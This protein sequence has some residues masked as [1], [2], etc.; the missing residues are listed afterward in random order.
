M[1]YRIL[2]PE[3]LN[4][5]ELIS[6]GDN[7]WPKWLVASLVIPT[8][9]V[10]SIKILEELRGAMALRLPGEV[11]REYYSGNGHKNRIH[12][13]LQPILVNDRYFSIDPE[14]LQEV[15]DE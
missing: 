12:T 10:W 15:L 1:L 14:H 4:E 6:A 2:K 5:I 11:Y 13:S 8:G 9:H 7:G 3:Y